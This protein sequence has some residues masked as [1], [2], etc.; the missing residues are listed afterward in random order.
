MSQEQ[1]IKNLEYFKRKLKS[2]LK[3]YTNENVITIRDKETRDNVNNFL[4]IFN[5]TLSF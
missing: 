3:I 1:E 2:F 4:F 5:T